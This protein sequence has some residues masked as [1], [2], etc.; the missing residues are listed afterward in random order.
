MHFEGDV[1][2]RRAIKAVSKGM[3]RVVGKE[4]KVTLREMK[5]DQA[6]LSKEWNP[7]QDTEEKV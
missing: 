5:N 3:K 4:A 6:L 7:V 1:C 2:C